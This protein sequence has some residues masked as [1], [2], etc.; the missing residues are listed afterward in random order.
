MAPSVP[1][2]LALAFASA[3]LTN[4]AYSFEHDAAA[5][6]PPLSPATRSGRLSSCSG[7]GAG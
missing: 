1:I 6:L 5:A 7:T 2:G 4:T 3:L